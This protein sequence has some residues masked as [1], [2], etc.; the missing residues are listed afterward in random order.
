MLP[1]KDGMTICRDLRH[2]WQG[3]IVLAQSRAVPASLSVHS[4]D[5]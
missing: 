2:R 1:G 4:G 5:G 3:P